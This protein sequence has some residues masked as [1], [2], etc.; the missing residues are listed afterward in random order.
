M[1]EITGFKWGMKER[2]TEMPRLGGCLVNQ[3]NDL[4][5]VIN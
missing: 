4:I 3:L 2:K 5:Q 1:L